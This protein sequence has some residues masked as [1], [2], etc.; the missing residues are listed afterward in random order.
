L[1]SSDSPESLCPDL[2]AWSL[3]ILPVADQGGQW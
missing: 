3:W 2:E 1:G